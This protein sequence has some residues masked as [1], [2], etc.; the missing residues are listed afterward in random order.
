MKTRPRTQ[1]TASVSLITDWEDHQRLARCLAGQVGW[2]NDVVSDFEHFDDFSLFIDVIAER[3][4]IDTM[5]DQ[6]TIVLATQPGAIGGVFSIHDN[7]IGSQLTTQ[8]I[9][10]GAGD[11]HARLADDVTDHYQSHT[12]GCGA[13][14][15]CDGRSP[16]NL[17]KA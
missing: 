11:A 8:P 3:D 13:A 17:N 16:S 12:I 4:P 9:H 14:G 6:A 10:R 1:V 7:R 15:R 2:T 5:V